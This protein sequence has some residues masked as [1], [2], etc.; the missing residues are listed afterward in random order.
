VLPQPV[1]PGWKGGSGMSAKLTSEQRAA[2]Y[3]CE[4]ELRKSKDWLTDDQWTR[5]QQQADAIAAALSTIDALTAENERLTKDHEELADTA[6][7]MLTDIAELNE[8]IAASDTELSALREMLGE[9]LYCIHHYRTG[10]IRIE[11]CQA[12]EDAARAALTT[13][14]ADDGS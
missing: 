14:G 9:L 4:D 11:A 13:K 1:V 10:G 5:F 7:G 8:I 12:A 2:L 6:M 3:A